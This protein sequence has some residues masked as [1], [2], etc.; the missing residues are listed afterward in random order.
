LKKIFLTL[1]VFSLAVCLFVSTPSTFA[2]QTNKVSVQEH[3]VSKFEQRVFELVNEERKKR[4]IEPLQLSLEVSKTAREKSEDMRDKDYFDHESPTYG[5]P[6]EHMKKKYCGENIAAQWKTPEEVMD[7]WMKSEG[8]KK[9][10]LRKEYTH[11]GVGYAEGGGR[12]GIYWTQQFFSD[13]Y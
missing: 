6:C 9:N 11:I 8:H 3:T 5:K 13:K 4:N 7:A 1:F 12:Y 2:Q 10:I